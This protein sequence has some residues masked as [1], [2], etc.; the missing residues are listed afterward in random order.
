[1]LH[2]DDLS[3]GDWVT[4]HTGHAASCPC[5]CG[6][7]GPEAYAGLKGLPLAITGVQLP[8]VVCRSIGR[9]LVVVDTRECRLMRVEEAYL[10]GFGV[11][12]AAIQAAQ[13]GQAC[14]VKEVPNGQ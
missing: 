4:V 14:E 8:Y 1:M 7:V 12:Q 11:E 6:S 2:V 13:G 9:Q 10:A 5:G 3:P